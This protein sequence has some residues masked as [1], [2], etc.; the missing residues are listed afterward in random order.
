MVGYPQHVFMKKQSTLPSDDVLLQQFQTSQD[1]NEIVEVLKELFDQEKIKL[2]TEL[3]D[4]EI[5]LITQ[6][7]VVAKL[8]NIEIWEEAVHYFMMLM[9][10]RKRKSRNEII[11]SIK[12]YGE[13]V[14]GF[15]RLLPQ[16]WG[17]PR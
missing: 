12:G 16:N 3:D 1:K 13:R 7:L 8:H 2:I 9:L 6:I 5:R 11:D 10:S 15:S 4:D 14:R 17:R